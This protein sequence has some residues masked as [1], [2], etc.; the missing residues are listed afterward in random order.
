MEIT[1]LN[2]AFIILGGFLGGVLITFLVM[3]NISVPYKSFEKLREENAKNSTKL[4][5]YIAVEEN[6]KAQL[7]EV[8]Q[9]L[10]EEQELNKAQQNQIGKL[11]NQC[12]N[13]QEKLDSQIK[14]FEEIRKQSLVQFENVASK[15]L[16]E[17]STKFSRVNKENMEQ[18]L[19]PLRENI[20]DFKKK[21][22]ETYDKESKERH[23]LESK[24]KELADLNQKISKEAKDLTNALKGQVKLKEIGEK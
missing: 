2:L 9:K 19:G 24:I 5:S 16:E 6:N 18:I 8:N 3:K 20:K 23:T 12:E 4:S 1:T 11:S 13:L 22:E 14:Q 15:L 21:V 10:K 17:K 7:L